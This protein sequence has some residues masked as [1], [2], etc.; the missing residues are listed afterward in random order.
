MQA[1]HENILGLMGLIDASE[2]EAAQKLATRVAITI[3][4][5]SE[6]QLFA[7]DLSAL[8][9]RS[10]VLVHDEACDI[11]VAVGGPFKTEAPRRVSITLH[12]NELT[13]SE[14]ANGSAVGKVPGLFRKIAA[15]YAAGNVIARAV[16]GEQFA[17]LPDPF[18]V[19]FSTFG[20]SSEDLQRRITLDDAV[21]V[22][23]GGVGN[24][25]MWAASELNL[26]GRLTIAD[27][28]KIAEGG[29]N[30]CLYFRP[31]D[32]DI[33]DKATI[34]AERTNRPD[35]TVEAFVGPFSAL[36]A[37]RGRVRRVFTTPDS[38]EV[39]RAIQ[40][41]LPL[42]VLDAST[43]DLSAVV[44]HS[45][46]QPTAGAC[47]SCIYPHLPIEDQRRIHMAEGLGLT[48]EEVRAGFIDE[49][50]ANKLAAIH[51]NLDAAALIGTAFDTV[52]KAQ[53]GQGALLTVAGQQ[54]VAPLAFIS[55]LAGALL[56]LELVR[57]DAHPEA[58]RS[59]Y[60]TLDPWRPP[61]AHARRYPPRNSSCEFCAGTS[62]LTALQA[63]WPEIE[64]PSN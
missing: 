13:V 57:F 5:H 10:L 15:C 32:V 41:E 16:G 49:A 35:F 7:S 33:C 51:P 18:I 55:N 23:A 19:K 53:C 63:V 59:T 24:G 1:Q 6:A 11:E 60:M 46:R 48:V 31:E 43:T 21:L 54:A 20:V 56:A 8:L 45:H 2:E 37:E 42:E 62:G 25:F 14:G 58:S 4:N 29:L 26:A 47:L 27:P 38:R 9:D 64:W 52:Y 22:G 3:A 50:I 36:V 28:K 34:L 30:R 44:V 39:R 61:H 17:G 40:N 12:D